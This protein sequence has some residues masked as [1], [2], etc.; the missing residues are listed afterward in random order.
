MSRRSSAL[1]GPPDDRPRTENGP[2]AAAGGAIDY[3]DLFQTLD[4][5]DDKSITRGEVPE[6]ARPAF[7]RLAK[8]ADTN[9]DGKIDQQEY[10]DMLTRARDSA[11]STV[12]RT[13]EAFKA[14]DKNGD[15]KLNRD[16]WPGL[17][18]MFFRVDAD[19]DGS[20]TLAEAT[21]FLEAPSAVNLPSANQFGPRFQAMDKNGDKKLTR[22][23]FTGVPANF[24]RIDTDKDGVLTPAEVRQFVQA[25]AAK[26][27]Q[28]AK[29]E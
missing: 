2:G 19:G 14:A 26:K 23:E 4:A 6:S 24:D 18:A 22:D 20:V 10:R 1:A 16:E 27:A 29:K 12:P 7:D 28:A 17:P 5:N 3:A 9:H 13:A 11:L 8:Q 15:G 25:N 21:R